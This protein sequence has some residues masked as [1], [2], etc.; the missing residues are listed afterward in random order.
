M[1]GLA[2]NNADVATEAISG[3]IAETV[4]ENPEAHHTIWESIKEWFDSVI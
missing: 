4:A 1:E 3:S 2:H